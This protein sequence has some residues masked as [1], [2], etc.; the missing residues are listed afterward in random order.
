[1]DSLDEHLQI[2]PV[3][4]LAFLLFEDFGDLLYI[5]L[6]IGGMQQRLG[7]DL[8]PAQMTA[9]RRAYWLRHLPDNVSD[10][11]CFCSITDAGSRPFKS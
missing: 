8:V 9:G 7:N 2:A 6:R 3:V 5:A 10:C 11:E 1:M 4:G